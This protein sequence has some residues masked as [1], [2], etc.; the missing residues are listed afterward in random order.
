[1]TNQINDN[2]LSSVSG[3][4]EYANGSFMFCGDH[5]EYTVAPGDVLSG[6]AERFNVSVP[7]LQMWN[8]IQN[9]DLI[10]IGQKL[11]IYPNIIR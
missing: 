6:I 7:Q 3:G 11:T 1:M 4:W 2:E 5:I 9:A 8:G 10:R